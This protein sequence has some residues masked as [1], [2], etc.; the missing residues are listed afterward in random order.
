MC[1]NDQKCT[2]N[3]WEYP[4]KQKGAKTIVPLQWTQTELKH[5]DTWKT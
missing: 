2:D 5:K 3:N 1:I 4:E